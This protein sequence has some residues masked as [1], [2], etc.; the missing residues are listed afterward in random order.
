MELGAK[1]ASVLGLGALELWAAV[2]AGLLLGLPPVVTAVAA[3][4]GALASS[5]LVALLGDRARTWLLARHGGPRDEADGGV[6]RR[7]WSRYGVVGLGLLAPL[8]VG[9]PLGTAIGLFLGSPVRQLL[10]W[11]GIGVVV[12][13]VGLTLAGVAGL[14][15]LE[16]IRD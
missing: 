11:I 8:L 4:L 3:G 9:A 16:A 5:V 15:G 12:W 13:S 10:T 14:T 2:P 6:I 1:V 7:I